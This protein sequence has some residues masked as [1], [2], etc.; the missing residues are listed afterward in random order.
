MARRT[1]RD[2][3]LR[4]EAE[5]DL[6]KAARERERLWLL[7][8]GGTPER[9]IEVPSAQLV[10]PRARSM[11]C[12]RC[13]GELTVAEHTAESL[14][15][16][17]LRVAH[18]ACRSCGARRPAYFSIAVSLPSLPRPTRAHL[19]RTWGLAAVETV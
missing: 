13:L 7:D 11:R 10:E 8:A 9:P 17:R 5:R 6:E 14:G 12:P 1:P 4:R 15:E 16:R 3:T 19:A 18:L 2:R